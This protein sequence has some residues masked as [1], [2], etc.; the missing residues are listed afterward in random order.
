[1]D[2]LDFFIRLFNDYTTQT[3]G[4]GTIF[5]GLMSGVLGV[6]AILRKQSLLGD[7][8]AHAS[9]PGIALAFLLSGTKNT[10]FI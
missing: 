5:L 1:M 10:L 2:Q 9:L 8:V 3:I 7:A 4:L 6:Y